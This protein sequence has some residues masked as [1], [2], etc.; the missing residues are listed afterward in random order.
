MNGSINQ[1]G[2]MSARQPRTSSTLQE[3]TSVKD[4]ELNFTPKINLRSRNSE[5]S[6][7]HIL[8]DT[9]ERMAKKDKL[10][11]NLKVK[12]LQ[13]AHQ[14]SPNSDAVLH[15]RFDKEFNDKTAE[16]EAKV[17]KDQMKGIFTELG[18]LTDQEI[19]KHD[20]LF[21]E[22]W[23]VLIQERSH[24]V[25]DNGE[26]KSPNAI[27]GPIHEAVDEN[28]DAEEDQKKVPKDFVKNIMRAIQNFHHQEVV[29]LQRTGLS[30][31][32]KNLGQAYAEEGLMFKPAEIEYISKR[33]TFLHKNRQDYLM[34]EKTTSHMLRSLKKQVYGERFSYQ[35]L[36]SQK[37]SKLA[38]KKRDSNFNRLEDRLIASKQKNLDLKAELG[39]LVP[40]ESF[41][42]T[43]KLLVTSFKGKSNKES[44][45]EFA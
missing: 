32:H 28:E 25:D 8:K 30:V 41:P 23:G 2:F 33:F 15:D 40:T 19:P 14:I 17:T 31:N 6:F 26:N 21:E 9:Q 22:V 13:S 29:D 37:T 38:V 34:R 11:T 44:E 36:V 43:P 3:Y 27:D 1:S 20:A 7:D 12:V 42:F 4:S 10:E 35:P 39:K 16:T 24:L 5:R 18:F 45:E